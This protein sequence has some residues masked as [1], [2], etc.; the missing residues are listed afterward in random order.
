MLS[1]HDI[2]AAMK[3]GDL[4]I[5]D[6]HDDQLQPASYDLR[7]DPMFRAPSSEFHA[8][9]LANVPEGH[10]FLSS[11]DDSDGQLMLAPGRFIL[12]STQEYFELGDTLGARVEGRSSLGRLGLMVHITAGFV[13]P[14]FCG[15][16]TFEVYNASPWT[17]TL[18]SGMKVAQ[19]AFFRVS[20][21]PSRT[22]GMRGHYQG[23]RG[24]TES[25]FKL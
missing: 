22:Y 21:A 6:F 24:P 7:L 4:L 25:R 2:V 5:E 11:M 19:L 9:D 15:N 18:H 13:D 17:L 3:R 16:I 23:Q 20:S 1:D 14:G 10:T 12:A 8:I